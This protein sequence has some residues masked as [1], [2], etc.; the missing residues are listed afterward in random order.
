MPHTVLHQLP[1]HVEGLPT[2]TTGED[3]VSR[4]RLF[5]LLQIAETAEP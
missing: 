1:L 5:V 3:L 2:F 4:V